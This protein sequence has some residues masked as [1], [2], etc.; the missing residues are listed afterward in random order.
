MLSLLLLCALTGSQAAPLNLHNRLIYVE[1]DVYAIN[2]DG[3]GTQKIWSVPEGYGKF[4][5]FSFDGARAISYNKF[6]LYLHDL[7]TGRFQRL[8]LWNAG[9][10]TSIDFP[11][12]SPDGKWVLCAVSSANTSSK[13]SNLLKMDVEQSY[14]IRSGWKDIERAMLKPKFDRNYIYVGQPRWSAN[15]RHI[16]ATVG[17]LQ[18]AASDL[19][20]DA[21]ELWSMDDD[22][23]NAQRITNNALWDELPS[24]DDEMKH[25]AWVR[26]FNDY[27]RDYVSQDAS[28]LFV[29][30][31]NGENEHLL[32]ANVAAAKKEVSYFNRMSCPL[33]SP[34]GRQIAFTQDGQ[35]HRVNTD[36][37]DSRVI[38]KGELI[39]WMR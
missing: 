29:M 37:S 21:L 13:D 33:F 20:G 14:S 28:E 1:G 19:G 2:P 4:G 39:Q 18:L 5:G 30:D 15:G 25:I 31:A 24:W 10:G 34:D 22:G 16:I 38:G 9:F 3:G 11:S 23:S 36:G 32:T 17:S 7:K 8:L 26:H 35:I 27:G 12:F 6:N